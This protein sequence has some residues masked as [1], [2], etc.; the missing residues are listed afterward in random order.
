VANSYLPNEVTWRREKIGFESPTTTWLRD[1]AVAS[2]SEVEGSDLANRFVSTREYVRNYEKLPEKIRW[3]I[4]NLA[5][6]GR[7]FNVS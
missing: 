5:V 7:V 1:G 3:S 2:T 6:W 4:Y